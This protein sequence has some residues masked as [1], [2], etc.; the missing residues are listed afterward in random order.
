MPSVIKKFKKNKVTGEMEEVMEAPDPNV[1]CNMRMFRFRREKGLLSWT[2]KGKTKVI[3]E[4]LEKLFGDKLINNSME[5]FGRDLT[6]KEQIEISNGKNAHFPDPDPTGALTQATTEGRKKKGATK[7]PK[8]QSNTKAQ[9]VTRQ[10]RLRDDLDSS[11]DEYLGEATAASFRKRRRNGRG[12]VSKPE[13]KPG[14]AQNPVEVRSDPTPQPSTHVSSRHPYED[15]D[16]SEYDE[17]DDGDDELDDEEYRT[18]T[19]YR[20]IY[21]MPARRTHT[22]ENEVQLFASAQAQEQPYGSDGDIESQYSAAND[23]DL[24]MTDAGDL[25]SLDDLA[26][27]VG[28]IENEVEEGL[29]EEEGEE[30]QSVESVSVPVPVNVVPQNVVPAEPQETDLE[31][32]RRVTREY[33]GEED[34]F[35]WLPYAKP[36]WLETNLFPPIPTL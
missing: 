11:E 5:S 12:E 26:N 14:K 18:R 10:K 25:D 32:H 1:V 3:G 9:K 22:G 33:L 19:S 31:R 17:F 20:P 36:T 28:S 7:A 6:P 27:D 21:P 24:D 35:Y 2:E 15:S 23:E 30:E 34:D 8:Q 13:V 29:E 4:G 16:G